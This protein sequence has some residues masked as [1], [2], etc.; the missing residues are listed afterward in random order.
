MDEFAK[1][2]ASVDRVIVLNI[3]ASA[4]ESVGTITGQD[5]V[6]AI[7]KESTNATYIPTLEE[8]TAF[9]ESQLDDVD[10][11]ITMGA[12]DVWRVGEELCR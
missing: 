10:V 2:F 12:G 7:N 4:R 9:L 6:N 3:Y 5:L 8:A 1:S 11:L